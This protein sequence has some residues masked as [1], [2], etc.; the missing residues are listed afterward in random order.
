MTV[1]FYDLMMH[2]SFSVFQDIF[3][4]TYKATLTPVLSVNQVFLVCL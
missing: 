3:F 4:V 2:H 1:L